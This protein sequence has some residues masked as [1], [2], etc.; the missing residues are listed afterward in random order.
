VSSVSKISVLF[1]TSPIVA[2]SQPPV[3]VVGMP[4]SGS[5]FLSHVL[6]AIDGWYVWDDLYLLQ[7]VKTLKSHGTLSKAQVDGLLNYLGWTIRAKL[8][9]DDD[10]TKPDLTMDDVDRF[11]EAMK[12]TYP[13]GNIGW[14][15]LLEEWMT[16]LARHHGFTR[17]GY[18][19][20]QDFHHMDELTDTFPGIHFVYIVRD[21]RRMMA[22]FKF[23]NPKDGNPKQYH[24]LVY[25]IYWKMAYRKI[26]RYEASNREPVLTVKFEDLVADPD[27][28]AATMAEFLDSE[29]AGKVPE[30]GRN[31]SF[32]SGKR[33]DIT[34]T[35]KWICERVTG[36]AMDALGYTRENPSFR[37][38]D[39]PDFLRTTVQFLFY[40]CGRIVKRDHARGSV[41]T[42]V[43]SLVDSR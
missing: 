1:H 16:R 29:L 2:E 37:L 21:P 13:E 3:V 15:T 20:P 8:T 17:W 35:E 36:P 34:E 23:V 25:A 40:Q 42:F 26:Q 38:R 22:S 33:K 4:R 18:K 31:T 32:G 43:R 10:F 12:A 39:I 24:P 6:S 5:S 14:E 11:V 28:A 9:H 27:G 30:Q 19:T 7:R 41:G